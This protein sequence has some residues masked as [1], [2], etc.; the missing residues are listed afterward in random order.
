M[1]VRQGGLPITGWEQEIPVWGTLGD[2]QSPEDLKAYQT[3]KRAYKQQLR[4]AEGAG[5]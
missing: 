2:V 4:E 1:L 3:R 5:A